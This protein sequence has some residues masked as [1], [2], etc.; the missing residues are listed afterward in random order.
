MLHILFPTYH[1]IKY[2]FNKQF[3]QFPKKTPDMN[4]PRYLILLVTIPQFIFPSPILPA[5]IY[6]PRKAKNHWMLRSH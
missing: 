6:S 2:F 3:N 1:S 4:I 5:N